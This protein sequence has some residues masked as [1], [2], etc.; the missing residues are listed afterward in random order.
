MRLLQHCILIGPKNP[1]MFSM[2]ANLLGPFC[3][4]LSCLYVLYVGCYLLICKNRKGMVDGREGDGE[5]G[6][7]RDEAEEGL[8]K[9]GGD[10]IEEEGAE[11]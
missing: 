2:V 7:G 1:T 8:G 3:N 4:C 6:V 10:G 9:K 5:K 11:G